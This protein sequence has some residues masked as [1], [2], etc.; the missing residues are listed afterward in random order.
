MAAVDA[1]GSVL[2]QLVIMI[3]SQV[4]A[5]LGKIIVF[6]DQSNIQSGWAG[7]T[8]AAVNTAWILAG[9]RSIQLVWKLFSS[10][11]RPK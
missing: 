7:M 2:F 1:V 3:E 5:S 8:M 9:R 4:I 10:S 11:D 6:V